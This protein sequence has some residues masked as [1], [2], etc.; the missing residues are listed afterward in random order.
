MKV[1]GATD[2][3]PLALRALAAV[4]ACKFLLHVLLAQR[5]GFHRDELYYLV[6]GRA[7][8][9]GYV[10]HP[11]FTPLLA[12]ALE[13]L[14]GS[15][16]FALRTAVALAGAA[17]V[18]LAGA[19]ARELGGRAWSQTLAALA[20]LASPLYLLTNG[21]FQ[22]VSFDQLAW[23]LAL[24][25]LTRALRDERPR[26]LLTFGLIV[27]CALLV[28]HTVVL[29]AFALLLALLLTRRRA[30]LATP[31]PW[32]GAGLAL[33]IA[34]PSLVW[35]VRNGWPTL[36]FI[37]ANGANAAR[38]FP[39]VAVAGLQLVFI[40]PVNLILFV[41]GTA[42]LFGRAR[43]NGPS[44]AV[45]R[46]LALLY[47]LALAP[48]LIRG[49]K[50]YYVAPLYPLLLAAG[51][52]ALER[53]TARRGAKRILLVAPAL[54][55]LG[56]LPLAWMV[57]PLAPRKLFAEHQD[58][59]PH[60]DFREMFGWP[61]LAEQ[62]A[63]VHATLPEHERRASGV[64]CDAYGEASAITVLGRRW[65]LPRA[66]SPHNQ[67]FLHGPPRTLHDAE[68]SVVIVVS[69]SRAWLDPLFADVLDTGPV[70]VPLGVRNELASKR[71]FVC[72]SPR[73]EWSALWPALRGVN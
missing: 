15:S 63:S 8:E 47:P 66:A 54:A 13:E 44:T 40:G 67:L 20:V 2:Q 21:L 71:I 64:L 69:G 30:W 7:L 1:A 28:K 11:P 53:W 9:W 18:F 25:V 26:A 5:Y 72:R 38:E 24:L 56:A 41:L 14:C 62:V 19:L 45:F 48:F 31:W 32:L 52:V 36:D 57:L 16:L 4:A 68:P 42:F 17:L 39:P 73:A 49:G 29:L 3:A 35:Q 37:V 58:A 12:R 50:P 59:W 55:L 22:T 61:E 27:G 6:C 23:T 10:D 65:N 33:S 43:A 51:A 60:S 34:A 46:P 70:R